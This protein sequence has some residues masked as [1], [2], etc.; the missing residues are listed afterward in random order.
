M[1][2]RAAEA[3]RGLVTCGLSHSETGR[4][5]VP[6]LGVPLIEVTLGSAAFL[7]RDF[8][9]I[10]IWF[11]SDSNFPCGNSYKISSLASRLLINNDNLKNKSFGYHPWILIG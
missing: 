2:D 9:G 4:F 3:S 1:G 6:P 10:R 5:S 7:L 8:K 11:L